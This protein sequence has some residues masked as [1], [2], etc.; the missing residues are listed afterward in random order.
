[1]RLMNA[2]CIV[3]RRGAVAACIM[4][5]ACA[6]APPSGAADPVG[7]NGY[8]AFL[9][10]RYADA[11]QDPGTATRF[12][13]QALAAD[14]DNQSLAG[15]AFIAALL[16]G[17]PRAAAL[18]GANADNALAVMLLGNNQALAGNYEAAITEFTQLPS[19]DL[20]GLIK[21]LLLA[22]A[23]AGNGAPAQAIASL[24]PNLNNGPFGPVYV[25]NAAMIADVSRD[26]ADASTYYAAAANQAPN[27]RLA[28]ILASWQARQGNA[29]AAR[30]ELDELAAAHPDLDIALPAL[31]A[32]VA[33]PVITTPLDGMAEAY[34]TLAG[35]LDQPSQLLLR[36]TF[37]RFA[38][39]LRPDLAAARL[40]LANVQTA[41][42]PGPNGAPAP[43]PTAV[44]MNQALA[45]LQPIGQ[46]DPLYGPAALQEADLL[47]ALNRPDE[48]VALLNRLAAATP[49]NPDAL[50]AAG[51]VLR[52]DN[53]Y[54]AAIGQYD[55]AIAMTG[56]P[57]PA[58]AWT[59]YFDRG[60]CEDQSGDW[61]AAQPDLL[62]ALALAP[63]QPYLL[64]YIGYSWAQRGEK[65]QQA[66]DMLQEAAGLG[67][68]DGAVIDSLGY[69]SL[70]QG[71]TADALNLLTQAVELDPD[72]AEVNAHLGDAFYAAGMKLQADYQW[73][74]ALSLKPDEKL[75]AEITG[76]LKQV[77]PHA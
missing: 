58:A 31:L 33:K 41:T 51:D 7:A 9:A 38:L 44:Q 71:H 11:Q 4:L 14:P 75:Q 25:L 74:R 19:D 40:L 22:W 42:Q 54:E 57:P 70:R 10:A 21:P 32:N 17:S 2:F 47:A 50:Q 43:P 49:G 16:A 62:N 68:N 60:I 46:D 56:Q 29:A 1:M 63:N 20:A 28:Q 48:A 61:N 67:P 23:E 24:G 65:L 66:H 34:L 36:T 15:E 35:S 26:M 59:L 52:G 12:Y 76:R 77:E 55:K 64:N 69:V 30:T 39:A 53:Q 18:A 37:L 8:G 6:A 27:L 73:Q 3:G 13:A 72:D 5:S 45:T